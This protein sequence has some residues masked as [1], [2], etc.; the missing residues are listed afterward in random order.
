MRQLELRKRHIFFLC[1]LVSRVDC[2]PHCTISRLSEK[3]AQ[4]FRFLSRCVEMPSKEGQFQKSSVAERLKKYNHV[5]R[6]NPFVWN[7][8]ALVTDVLQS[9]TSL[10]NKSCVGADLPVGKPSIVC[11]RIN[12]QL[13]YHFQGWCC[14]ISEKENWNSLR[15]LIV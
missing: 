5:C 14:W 9:F 7:G 12:S 1:L 3:S 2:F 11:P 8:V 15:M 6:Y 10:E 4:T 13:Q